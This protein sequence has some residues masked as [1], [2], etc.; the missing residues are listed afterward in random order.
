MSFKAFIVNYEQKR[1]CEMIEEDSTMQSKLDYRFGWRWLLPSCSGQETVYFGLNHEEQK[2]WIQNLAKHCLKA[3][4]ST[5]EGCLIALDHYD[6][7]SFVDSLSAMSPRWIC[8]WG[9]GLNVNRLRN[10]LGEFGSI[11][12]YALLPAGRPR[13][14]VPLSSSKHVIAGLRLHRPGRW[15]AQL[16]LLAAHGLAKFGYLGLVRQRVLLVAT[17]SPGYPIGVVHA[18]LNTHSLNEQF[19]YVLYLGTPDD[20]RKT[21]VLPL[22]DVPP[23][24]IL[25][26]AESPKARV[27]VENEAQVLRDLAVTPLAHQVPKLIRVE[28]TDFSI[29]L[30]QEYRHRVRIAAVSMN[31][32][33]IDFLVVMSRQGRY[34]R[35]LADVLAQSDLMTATRA[36]AAKKIAY[37]RI[38]DYLDT[39]AAEGEIVLGHRSHGDFAPWNCTWTKQGFFVFDWE[40]SQSWDVALGDA[41]YFAIASAVCVAHSQSAQAVE[42]KA[43]KFAMSLAKEINLSIR[44]IR[45]Y[46]LI[47][48]LQR[49]SCQSTT[50]YDQLLEQQTLSN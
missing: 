8:A 10:S 18:K 47:W 29:T 23:D 43:F 35:P 6:I 16:G 17:R 34:A 36:R 31:R 24:V 20:N 38:R 32:A 48:L 19:D 2:W 30:Y 21:V 26:V 1:S 4:S 27:A 7:S 45:V 28:Q 50:F 15:L 49:T 9:T 41:F 37:A 3:T 42:A 46:W 13:V 5:A 44:D 22:G 14:V 11:R 40:K 12:E 33:S 39:L 25:K